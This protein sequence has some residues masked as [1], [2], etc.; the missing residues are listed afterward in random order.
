MPAPA[1]AGA[2]GGSVDRSVHIHA[3]AIQIHATKID[4]RT[5]MQIDRE[6]ARLIERRLERQ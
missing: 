5:A 6:L 1:L 2:G 3:G 4:E